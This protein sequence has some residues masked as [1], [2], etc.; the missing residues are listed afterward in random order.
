MRQKLKILLTI[1]IL[2]SCSS[3][4]MTRR[5]DYRSPN[6]KQELK[7]NNTFEIKKYSLDKT[8]GYTEKNPVMVGGNQEGPENERRF[9]NALSGPNGEE[10]DYYRIGSCCNFRT[11]NSNYG[12]GGLLDMYNVTYEGLI[13]G[14]VIYINMYDS[15]TL[16]VPVGLELKR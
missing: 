12:S 4:R 15:D 9:L 8:Y 6:I 2:S 14:L 7:D 1:L 10:L 13:D 3:S 5:I 11:K 16:K